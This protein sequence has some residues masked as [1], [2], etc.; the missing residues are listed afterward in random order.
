MSTTKQGRDKFQPRAIPCVFLGYP[1]GKKAYKVMDLEHHKVHISRDVVFHE[2]IF[3]YENKVTQVLFPSMNAELPYFDFQHPGSTDSA[4]NV[5]APS[6]EAAGSTQQAETPSPAV[7]RS[8]GTHRPPHYLKDYVLTAQEQSY[9]CITLTNLSLHPPPLPLS[10]LHLTSQAFLT[11]LDFVEPQTYVEAA[12]HPGWQEAMRKELQALH[13][14]H[15]W[16]I[17]SLPTGKKPIACKWVYRVKC[18]ADGSIERLKARLVVKG[19]TQRKGIDY[20]ETFSP[21]IKLATIRVLMT[22]AVKKGWILHQLDVNNAFLHGDLHE[23]IYMQLPPGVHSNIPRA[24][25]KLQ[26]SLYGLKQASR[27]WYEKLSMVLLQ[28]GY[29]H[30]HNDYSLFYKK[31]DDSVVFLAVYVDDILVTGNNEAEINSLKSFLDDTFKIKDLGE[32]HYFLGIEVLHTD[33]GLLLTQRKFTT[34]LLQEFGCNT[35]RSVVCPLDY[36]TKLHSDEGEALNN[37]TQYRRLIGK[38]NFLTNTRPDIAFAVQHLSQFLQLPRQ[39]H[40]KAALHVLQYLKTEPALGILLSN[41]PSFDLLAYCD[42]DWA[43]C[44]HTR[45]SVSGFLVFLGNTLISWKSKKQVTVSL[46]SAE[47]EYRSLRRLTAEL[48]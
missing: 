28:R 6:A 23:E 37:P 38:L 17:V 41:S 30:S 33:H 7:K 21:V 11:H 8:S 44:P 31:E 25:C 32:V 3:P 43:S 19:F 4:Q 15:T 47:A 46:S 9:C 22:I 39:P 16:T 35:A 40:M 5:P 48:A 2:A 29:T 1:Y 24:V 34:E 42:A 14:T 45:K 36:N 26:K 10:Q 18:K 12:S 20:M 13:D 27:Q